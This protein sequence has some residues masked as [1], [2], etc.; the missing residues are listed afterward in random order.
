MWSEDQWQIKKDTEY[1]CAG[2]VIQ[3][4]ANIC[5]LFYDKAHSHFCLFF[6]TKIFSPLYE[7]CVTV[8]FNKE[9][10]HKPAL[11]HVS[12]MLSASIRFSKGL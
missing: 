2:V 10:R 3:C 7:L 6:I 1:A 12:L 5:F 9:I 4:I 8:T 11:M